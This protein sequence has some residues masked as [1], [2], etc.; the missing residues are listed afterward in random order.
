[1]R[2]AEQNE[3]TEYVKKLYAAGDLDDEGF[4]AGLAGLLRA[5]TDDQLADVVRTLPPPVSL[6][7]AD[8]R[9]AE[10][11]RIRSGMRR[12]RRH[13]CWQLGAET[14]VSADLGSVWLD[15]TEAQFDDHDIDLH[16]STGWG[17]IT[18]IVPRGVGVQVIQARGGL[19]NELDPPI[20]GFPQ[21]RLDAT[22]NIGRIRLR[23]PVGGSG[24]RPARAALPAASQPG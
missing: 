3:A 14:H 19:R 24:D 9:L 15:L 21:I 11:L 1:M 5:K 17:A 13:G 2:T 23:H 16:V 22:T 8:Q 20:P 18:I 7:A 6:T 12:L 10:P 4:V